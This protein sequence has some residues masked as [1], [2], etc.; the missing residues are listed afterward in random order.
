MVSKK[1]KIFIGIVSLALILVSF[2]IITRGIYK[3]FYLNGNNENNIK[4]SILKI[5]DKDTSDFKNI[6]IIKTI[7]LDEELFVIYKNNIDWGVAEFGKNN[8]GDYKIEYL[9]HGY[10]D[11]IN[12]Y[13]TSGINSKSNQYLIAYG[14]GKNIDFSRVDIW[15]N[16]NY[17]PINIPE[18]EFVEIIKINQY[19]DNNGYRFNYKY[20]DINGNIV[21]EH[22]YV[23]FK[24]SYRIKVKSLIKNYGL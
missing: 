8:D 13:F 12:F 5:Q 3:K 21:R 17:I 14:E 11:E 15:I 4:R 16:N 7:H 6:V 2:S 24:V 10:I 1:K 18:E 22:W 20:Y 9:Q 19:S 23:N